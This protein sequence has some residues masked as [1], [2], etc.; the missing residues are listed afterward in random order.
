M[1]GAEPSI[2]KGRTTLKGLGEDGEEEEENSVEEEESYGTEVVPAPVGESEGTGRPALALSNQPVSHQSEPSLLAT[3]HQMTQIMANLQES[4]PSKASRPPALK[5]LSMKIPN[6]FYGTQ[7]SKKKV[8]YSSSFLIGRASKCIEPYVSNLSN[9]DPAYLLNDW[10][11]FQSQ[12]FALFGDPNEVIKSESEFDAL[13][14]KER[15]HVLIYISDFRSLVSRIG[16]WGESALIHHFRKE[17][18]SHPSIISSLQDLMDV[19]LELD[20]RCHEEKK[21]KNNF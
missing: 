20:T 21:E 15:G 1:E 5:T 7:P 14:M 4:L 12:L 19:T 13:R 8:L 18:S 2:Y 16:D 10:A 11:L 6:F 9:Q 3:M 17:L